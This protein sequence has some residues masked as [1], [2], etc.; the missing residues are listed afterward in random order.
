[1][2]PDQPTTDRSLAEPAPSTPCDDATNRSWWGHAVGRR[3]GRPGRPRPLREQLLWP[4]YLRRSRVDRRQ[5]DHPAPGGD[6]ADPF[7]SRPWQDG[8]R[9]AVVEPLL[10]TQLCDR[11]RQHQGLSC[12]EP[13]D[14]HPQRA[15]LAGYPPS[16]I[17]ASHLEIPVR[18]TSLQGWPWPL[19]C[20]GSSI[21]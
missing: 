5:P 6:F 20:C 2:D 19:H 8:Q 4:V 21:P 13:R 17:H 18:A 12:R 9:P 7:P 10:R 14:P 3:A 15:A 11:R 1:M 16:H